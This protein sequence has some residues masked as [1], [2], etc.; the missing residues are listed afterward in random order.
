MLKYKLM[1]P[2]S[3][4]ALLA[5]K[6][7]N[8]IL[9]K[10]GRGATAAPGL[11]ATKIDPNLLK[12]LS[13][14]ITTTIIITG[15]NGKTTT[16]R[17]IAD[18]LKK[19][20]IPTIHNRAGSNLVRGLV[21]TLIENYPLPPKAVGLFEVDEATIPAVLDQITPNIVVITNLFRDQLDR[22]GEV[23]KTHRLWKKALATL[24]TET[25][26]ILNSDDPNVADLGRD[27][28]AT[29]VSFG[30][31]DRSIATKIAPHTIDARVCPIDGQPL[32]YN[33]FY[34]SH[35]GS[36]HCSN[37][38]FKRPQ[39][40][41]SAQEIKLDN[42]NS[43]QLTI[44]FH[45][46][47]LAVNLP[48]SGLYNIYNALAAATIAHELDIDNQTIKKGLEDFR[49]AF[50]RQQTL[51]VGDKKISLNL[52]KNPVGYNEV[53]RLIGKEEKPLNL[54]L[55]LNDRLADGTDVSWIWDVDFEG[56]NQKPVSV[57]ISGHR[58]L[59]LANRIKY[60]TIF[61]GE[62]LIEED[63][64]KALTLALNNLKDEETLYTLAT[65]T[66]MLELQQILTKGGHTQAF[67]EN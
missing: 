33:Y 30:L 40:I 3:L 66:A 51:R 46:E 45:G 9:K 41:I 52:V 39:P 20:S 12:H 15:T 13:E 64:Q 47:K 5:G 14:K 60:A 6:S 59:E 7:L 42:L 10:S 50:G 62:V 29:V 61:K 21:S 28:K 55:L 4:T 54:L 63:P 37:G 18:I 31:D 1:N 67:W 44:N 27:L 65:Y 8:L 43:A 49:A 48:I 34:L 17:F 25:T 58:A 19:Q 56:L 26:V 23:A 2:R 38:D 57:T 24:P 35:L 36:Y 11:Y 53:I 32:K 22:Y 16:S